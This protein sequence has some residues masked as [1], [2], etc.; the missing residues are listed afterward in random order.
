[1]NQEVGNQDL[2]DKLISLCK[3]RG[4]IFPGSEIYGG[5]GH[6]LGFWPSWAPL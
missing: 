5:L 1:M 3:Q 2:M 6:S 4:I